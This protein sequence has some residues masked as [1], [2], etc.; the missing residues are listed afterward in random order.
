MVHFFRQR[1]SV[2]NGLPWY[3]DED[4]KETK[5]VIEVAQN[6]DTEVRGGRPGIYVERVRTMDNKKSGHRRTVEHG[7]V[8]GIQ[9]M[10]AWDDVRFKIDAL[11]RN[12][13]ESAIIGEIVF[14]SLQ[15]GYIDIER[16]GWIR[17]IGALAMGQTGPYPLD[18]EAFNTP[19]ETTVEIEKSWFRIPRGVQL[20]EILLS[21]SGG[22]ETQRIKVP[23]DDS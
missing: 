9:V 18:V 16:S 7:L 1:F 22:P 21:L 11:G 23:G 19:T 5:I 14:C 3:W 15:E 2:V 12:K 13:G 8:S 20:R 4:V 6:Y 10:M 17:E